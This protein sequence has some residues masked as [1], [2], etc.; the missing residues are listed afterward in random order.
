MSDDVAAELRS[1][2]DLLRQRIEQTAAMARQSEQRMAQF[3][4]PPMPAPVDFAELEAKR[5]A[6]DRAR[7]EEGAR[8]Y[9]DTQA[10]RERLLAALERQND[11]LAQLVARPGG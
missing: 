2:A 5:D 11:L 7:R 3:R 9:A 8:R 4:A 1:I 10:F 6:A